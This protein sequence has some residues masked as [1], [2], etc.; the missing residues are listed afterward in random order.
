MTGVPT[1]TISWHGPS[2][3][4][5]NSLPDDVV[6]L[7]DGVIEITNA[8]KSHEGDYTCQATNSI[9]EASDFGTIN[10]GLSLVFFQF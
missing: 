10:I 4:G 8:K 5:A 6:D 1:P 7:G 2:K 9:G 3:N